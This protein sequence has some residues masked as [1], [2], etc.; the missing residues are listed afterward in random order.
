MKLVFF[1][2][3]VYFFY[4]LFQK[5][6]NAKYEYYIERTIRNYL[7]SKFNY[8]IIQLRLKTQF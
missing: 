4:N 2:Y 6:Q 7:C 3:F 8:K 5:F 1:F